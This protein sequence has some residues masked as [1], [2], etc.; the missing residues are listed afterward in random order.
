MN[1]P[2]R[3]LFVD[4]NPD[5]P[6]LMMNVLRP[7]FPDAGMEQAGTAPEFARALEHNSFDLAIIDYQLIWSNGIEVLRAVKARYPDCPVIMATGTGS[8]EIA[9]EAMKAGLD[10]YVLKSIKHLVRLP[11][12][13]QTVLERTRQRLAVKEAEARYKEA[14]EALRKSEERFRDLVESSSDWLWEVNESLVFTYSS[15]RARDLLGYEP[16]EITGKSLRDLMPPEDPQCVEDLCASVIAGRKPFELLENAYRRKDGRPVI[17]E[18]SGV[19]FFGSDGTFRGYRAVGRDVTQRKESQKVLREQLHF[20]QRLMD[21]FPNPLFYKDL[22]GLYRGCNKAFEE[23]HGVSRERIIGKSA[24]DCF[25]KDLADRFQAM[26]SRLMLNPGTRIHENVRLETRGIGRDTIVSKATYTNLDGSLGGVVGI[27]V[28]VTE[29]KRIQE[30]RARLAA[31]IDQ[32]TE[33][34]FVTDANWSVLYVNQAFERLS[35][36]SPEEAVGCCL[37]DFRFGNLS[38]VFYRDKTMKWTGPIESRA[39]GGKDGVV[40]EIEASISPILDEAG[41]IIHYVGVIRDIS[42][43]ARLEKLLRQAQKMEALGT[44]AGGIAHDFN[45]ILG[46]VM[47]YTELTLCDTPEDSPTRRN[48][49]Q[50]LKASR[51]ARDLVQQILAFSRQSEQQRHPVSVGLIVKEALKLLRASL[52]STIE[53]SQNIKSPSTVLADPTQIHQVLMNLCSNSAHAMREKGGVLRVELADIDMDA[54][55]ASL[56]PDMTPGPYLRLTV[57]DTG[58][59]IDPA[60]AERIFDPYFTTKDIG[61]GTGLGLAVVH[62]IVKNHGGAVTVYSEPGH[63]TTFHVLLPRLVIAS[64]RKARTETPL[65]LA[66][67]RERIL[68]VDDEKALAEAGRQMLERLGYQVVGITS[69]IEALETFKAQPDFFDLVITDQTMPQMTGLDLARSLTLIR[70]GIPIILCTGFSH[71]L[72]EIPPEKTAAMGIREIVMKPVIMRAIAETARKVLDE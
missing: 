48:L 51:R 57:S 29:Q 64:D 18:T 9:V 23:I 10:D 54:D 50:V 1:D 34:V 7:H 24:H 2:L 56:Q 47:G 71:M 65:P 62:G 35:G 39:K 63:G 25:P 38:E 52:P 41:E 8:E 6:V 37:R 67:G 12:V 60:I 16:E 28:D 49:D 42:Q 61:E 55:H 33:G 4:D 40:H 46:A 44:L 20:L 19:P 68:F 66:T 22:D 5:D 3:I 43:E 59:G 45:N 30:D 21:S 15:P 58:H 32:I 26:D 31:A 13:V 17:L 36:L 70:P 27:I 53:V 11:A 72:A 14:V 69:P